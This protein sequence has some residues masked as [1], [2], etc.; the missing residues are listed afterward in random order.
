MNF[1]YELSS[2]VIVISDHAILEFYFKKLEST[3]AKKKQFNVWKFTQLLYAK[4]VDE[5]E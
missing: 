5:Y 3:K 1:L 4:V 2:K